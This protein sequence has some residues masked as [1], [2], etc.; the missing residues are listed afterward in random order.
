MLVS[1]LALHRFTPAHSAQTLLSSLG[2][3]LAA[4][5]FALLLYGVG[6]CNAVQCCEM[7]CSEVQ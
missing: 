6:E 1:M 3:T 2:G 5:H 7:W 4:L